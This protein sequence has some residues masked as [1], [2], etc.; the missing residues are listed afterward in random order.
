MAKKDSFFE[1][2]HGAMTEAVEAL[3]TGRPLTVREVV[4]P[5]PPRPM[6]AQ[7][8]IRLR[9][10]KMGVSQA[11]LA[12]LANTAVQTVQAWEQ[13]RTKPS[14]SALRLLRLM[15]SKPDIVQDIIAGG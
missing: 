14:G 12:S 15:D 4:L 1:G 13:G 8:I 9:R 6:S 10:K 7:Q 2:L 3:R 11:V 5:A